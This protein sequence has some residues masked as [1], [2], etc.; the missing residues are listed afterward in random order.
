MLTIDDD[1]DEKGSSIRIVISAVLVVSI[2]FLL[3][4]YEQRG[5]GCTETPIPITLNETA[6]SD[7]S[8]F[9]DHRIFEIYLEQPTHVRITVKTQQNIYLKIYQGNSEYPRLSKTHL[10]RDEELVVNTRLPADE[11]YLL[12]KPIGGNSGHF[13]INVSDSF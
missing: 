11:L 12:V 5:C 2:L 6:Q 3:F 10:G 8:T 7:F 9:H 4:L 1:D 13:T